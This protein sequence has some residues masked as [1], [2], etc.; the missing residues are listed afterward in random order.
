MFKIFDIKK[1]NK[2]GALE[3]SI[4]TIVVIVI[5]MALLG[6]GLMFIRGMFDKITG[7]SDS[8]FEKIS[9]QLNTDLVTSDAPLIFS[10]TKITID[11]GGNSQEGF[12]VKNDGDSKISYGVKVGTFSCPELSQSE[13]GDCPDISSW[14]K[15]F[16]GDQQYTISPAER[17]TGKVQINVPRGATTGLYLLKIIAYEGIFD[18]ASGIC[19]E[20]SCSVFGQTELFLTVA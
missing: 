20:G 9:E 6:L 17:Q 19:P 5:A 18:E 7:V 13:N 10:K 14:F 3:L 16:D 8:T 12:G 1:Q 4:N 15:Y 11:R 2:R